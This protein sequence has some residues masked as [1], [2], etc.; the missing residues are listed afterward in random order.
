MHQSYNSDPFSISFFF[1]CCGSRLSSSAI[2]HIYFILF[3]S[4]PYKNKRTTWILVESNHTLF[5]SLLLLLLL[6]L[7]KDLDGIENSFLFLNN[8]KRY[9]QMYA[10]T[11]SFDWLVLAHSSPLAV[12][13]IE[14]NPLLWLL[15]SNECVI[16]LVG[17]WIIEKWYMSGMRILWRRNECLLN[18]CCSCSTCRFCSSFRCCTP[19]FSRR[20]IIYICCWFKWIIF[21]TKW[22][23]IKENI[24]IT[25]NQRLLWHLT[26]V[27][28]ERW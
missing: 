13:P 25:F 10:G 12:A 8:Y 27:K 28:Q 22:L 2:Y 1:C 26:Q 9:Q 6:L 14:E 5:Y 21:F 23:S 11:N 17:W 4:I 7:M 20:T 19:A 18:L 15:L 16:V 3:S 24:T